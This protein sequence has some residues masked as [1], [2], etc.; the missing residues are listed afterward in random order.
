MHG[1]DISV[2]AIET[3]RSKYDEKAHFHVGSMAELDFPDDSF[4]VVA[5]LEGIEHVEKTVAEKFLG[6][7]R[8]VLDERGVLIISSPH[9]NDSP[10]SGNP[11]HVHEYQPFE[12]RAM[13]CKY[14][15][16]DKELQRVVDN[17]TVTV[18]YC[19]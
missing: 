9:C 12:M 5:C 14:F 7:T 3:A 1:V 4:D 19:V 6:E 18:F 10:H 8:R 16:I 2:E 15:R 13:L 11:Y 17:L